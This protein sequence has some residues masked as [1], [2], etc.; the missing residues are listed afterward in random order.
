MKYIKIIILLFISALFLGAC[1]SVDLDQTVDPSSANPNL[2]DPVFA[3]NYVQIELAD[4][5]DRTN[6]F[7]QRVTRQMAMTGGNTYENAFAPVNF[8]GQWSTGYNIMNAV[9]T[10]EPKARETNAN[11]I[12]GA[13]KVVRCYVLMTFVD[14]YGRIPYSQSLLGVENITPAYDDDESVYV[15]ILGE[16]DDAIDLLELES[17]TGVR[18]QDLYYGGQSGWIKLAKTLKLRMYNNCNLLTTVGDKVVADEINALVSENDL[19]DTPADDFAFRYGN[20]RFNPNSRHPLYNDQYEA[21]GG[22]YIANYIMWAMTTEK[23]NPSNFQNTIGNPGD[24]RVNY[25]FFRQ[26]P[27]PSNDDNFTLPGRVQPRPDHYNDPKYRSFYD[28]SIRACYTVSNWISGGIASNGF[29]GRDH[30]NNAGIPPD[31]DKRT[32]AGLYPIGG[33]FGTAASVQTNG[34]KGVLGA[35]IMPIML[36]SWVHFMKAE[37]M[38]KGIL[39]GGSAGAQAELSLAISQSIQKSTTLFPDYNKGLAPDVLQEKTADY[40]SFIEDV[41]T[42]TTSQERKLE[43]IMKEFYIATWG[44]GI[45]PYNNYRRTGYPSNFQPTL[46][47]EPGLFFN[48]ALYA[49]SSVNNNPNVPT[50]DRT[51]KVF[52]AAPSVVDLH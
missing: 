45:E 13:S 52:W 42:D 18:T 1:E 7:T 40:L 5:V 27:D 50:N 20:S 39:S 49:G 32:V 12:L 25:Y 26:D 23:G 9:K 48:A 16:L 35:G 44:N 34:N 24:P 51:R 22:S 6:S 38:M 31:Q 36:S 8:D 10:L 11:Y 14:M 46:E 2:L 43:L 19:I 21:G 41:F 29:W 15:G 37:L 30:G 17:N 33:E 4:F 47:P 3:F 28:P